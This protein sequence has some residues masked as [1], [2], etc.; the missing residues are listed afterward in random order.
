M[1]QET[2]TSSPLESVSALVLHES[3]TVVKVWISIF[4]LMRHG[5]LSILVTTEHKKNR[6]WQEKE[7]VYNVGIKK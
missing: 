4:A 5:P 6:K 2:E 1:K 7:F 3:T